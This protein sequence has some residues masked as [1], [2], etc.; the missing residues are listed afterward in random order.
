MRKFSEDDSGVNVLLEYIIN[1]G[2]LLVLLTIVWLTYQTII[3]ES[4]NTIA[5][6]EYRVFANDLANRI[7]LFDSIASSTTDMGRDLS[8]PYDLVLYFDTPSELGDMGYN[9]DITDNSVTVS[10]AD[11]YSVDPVTATFNTT[12][13]VKTT[14]II[15]SS[16]THTIK[17]NSAVPEIEVT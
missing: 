14:K 3:T 11:R 12:Y 6:E 17:F 16:A 13:D 2:T 10:S 4:N 8:A 7:V 15:G 9:I 5:H 1:F